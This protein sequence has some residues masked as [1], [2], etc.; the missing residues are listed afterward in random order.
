MHANPLALD[1]P[2]LGDPRPPGPAPEP[3]QPP[4]PP[5]PI[6]QPPAPPDE[7][8]VPTALRRSARTVASRIAQHA[9]RRW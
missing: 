6:P 7:P 8:P 3:P 4:A 5:T 9:G 2:N 1:R